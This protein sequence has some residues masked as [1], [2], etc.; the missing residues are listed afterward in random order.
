MLGEVVVYVL[1][2]MYQVISY[3]MSL[4]RQVVAE[5]VQLFLLRIHYHLTCSRS[6]SSYLICIHSR[7]VTPS[8]NTVAHSSQQQSDWCC[9]ID[10]MELYRCGVVFFPV[11]VVFFPVGIQ[12]CWSSQL[13]SWF[14][15]WQLV[16]SGQLVSRDVAPTLGRLP[17]FASLLQLISILVA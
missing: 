11:G 4:A 14:G 5:M 10:V 9:A 12:C 8:C 13:V 2:V 1:A 16:V 6:L 15:L 3:S 7:Y 17:R